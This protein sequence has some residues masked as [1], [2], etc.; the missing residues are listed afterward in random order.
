MTEVAESAVPSDSTLERTVPLPEATR[1]SVMERVRRTLAREAERVVDEDGITAYFPDGRL[2][3]RPAGTAP[4]CRVSAHGSSPERAAA[5]VDRGTSLVRDLVQ[6]L[7]SADDLG[8][9]W[10]DVA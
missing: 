9:L 6:A 1:T 5:L 4:E 2:N 10:C 7:G 8:D 3:L